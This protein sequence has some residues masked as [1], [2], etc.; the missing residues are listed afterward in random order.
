MALKQSTDISTTPAPH[1]PRKQLP[2]HVGKDT[3]AKR[4][5]ELSPVFARI[6]IRERVARLESIVLCLKRLAVTGTRIVRESVPLYGIHSC[7][8]VRR[9]SRLATY[10]WLAIASQEG[11]VELSPL[12]HAASRKRAKGLCQSKPAFVRVKSEFDLRLQ[13]L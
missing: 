3:I 9:F 6:P 5:E 12:L 2:C 1:S 13:F 7:S 10:G 11:H 8:C 4:K